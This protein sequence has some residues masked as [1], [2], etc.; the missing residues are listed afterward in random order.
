MTLLESETPSKREIAIDRIKQMVNDDGFK[1]AIDIF[2]GINNIIKFVSDGD[3][4]KFMKE[5]NI[6][7][8]IIKEGDTINMY[9]PDFII[10]TLNLEDFSSKEKV[11]GEFGWGRLNSN[12]KFPYKMNVRVRSGITL[13]GLPYWHVVGVG[14]SYGFGYSFITKKETI[15][16]TF[17]R[18]IFNQ[19]IDKYNL[20]NII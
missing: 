2:G 8:Y 12:G 13:K 11:M 14:G 16:K 9:I 19:I 10:N 3:V 1:S 15:G 6:E 20:N 7:P 4:I 5:F 17:R 18:Q